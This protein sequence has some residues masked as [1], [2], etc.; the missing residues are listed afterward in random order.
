MLCEKYHLS[1]IKHKGNRSHHYA[2]WK[3]EKENRPTKRSLVIDDVEYAISTSTT[4]TQFLKAL[5]NMGYTIREGKYISLKPQSGERAFRLHKLTKD[6]RYDMSIIEQRLYERRYSQF[7]SPRH[8]SPYKYYYKGDLNKAR[9]LTSFKA[10]Y[11][12][13]MF[14]LGVIP[15]QKPAPKLSYYLKQDL[16]KLDQITE[17]VTF[18]SKKKINTIEELEF[19]LKET[20]IQK[21]SLENE[22][23]C[24]YGK[25]KRC[26]NADSKAL[27]L[28][29]DVETMTE[30][31]KSLRKEVVLYERIKKRSED[32]KSK[33]K[34]YSELE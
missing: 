14:L 18:L 27:V 15:N 13:Y 26:R 29:Q 20:N 9:K 21:H 1:V 34:Y 23:K 30:Q 33:I 2:E 3:A 31:I 5:K 19:S 7:E 6:G 22:R 28:Q 32:M 24:I 8:T 4:K 10:L 16:L 11:V 25:I 12:H 17:E